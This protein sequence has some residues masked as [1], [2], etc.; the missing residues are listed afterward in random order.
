MF[1]G[2]V[3]NLDLL[4]WLG[5]GGGK[6]RACR[7]PDGFTKTTGPYGEVIDCDTLQCCH[8][9]GHFEVLAGSGRLRGFCSRHAGY[10]CGAPACMTVCLD[11][12]QR[13]ENLE[14]GRPMLHLPTG[15][16]FGALGGSPPRKGDEPA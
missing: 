12:E 14:A 2:F 11:K 9:G 1:D 15:V 7:K 3:K 5:F 6:P 16:T 8:C 10:V 13:L 4:R